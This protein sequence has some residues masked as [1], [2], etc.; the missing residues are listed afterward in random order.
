MTMKAFLQSDWANGKCA[1]NGNN[2]T[3]VIENLKRIVEA[4]KKMKVT[5]LT[6]KM[7]ARFKSRLKSKLKKK[8]MLKKV[9]E[10]EVVAKQAWTEPVPL[11]KN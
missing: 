7:A 3:K 5:M 1:L 6:V 8:A 9:A 10:E 2:N 11:V 4:R